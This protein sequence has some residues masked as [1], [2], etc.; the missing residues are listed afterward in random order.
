MQ[1]SVV[2]G[3]ISRCFLSPCFSLS[4]FLTP[5]PPFLTGLFLLV[6][7]SPPAP[8]SQPFP[9][10]QPSP[11]KNKQKVAACYS[12]RWY[13]IFPSK[14]LSLFCFLTAKSFLRPLWHSASLGMGAGAP[15]IVPG[16]LATC[17]LADKSRPCRDAR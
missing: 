16:Y 15:L 9:S 5:A 4:L 14:T 6:L 2:G 13:L 3:V 7:S 1:R 17:L 10:N 8:R 11:S 12:F